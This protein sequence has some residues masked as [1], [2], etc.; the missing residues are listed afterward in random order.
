MADLI[1][2]SFCMVS[3]WTIWCFLSGHA[4]AKMGECAHQ[5]ITR[6]LEG[7]GAVSLSTLE[8]LTS[9]DSA[10][11]LT[12][13][14]DQIRASAAGRKPS[15]PQS[16]AYLT[17]KEIQ[18]KAQRKAENKKRQAD[19]VKNATWKIFKDGMGTDFIVEPPPAGQARD[20]ALTKAARILEN[21]DDFNH[22]FQA[23]TL[24]ATARSSLAE[25]R[26]IKLVHVVDALDNDPSTPLPLRALTGKLVA[27]WKAEKVASRKSDA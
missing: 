25:A 16:S 18:L 1:K 5:N 22:R 27:A 10:A 17:L 23:L 3:P 2:L 9:H 13:A 11:D 20:S 12:S 24:A 4:F 8:D 26:R 7:D 19:E 14:D 21:H 6:F 15:L